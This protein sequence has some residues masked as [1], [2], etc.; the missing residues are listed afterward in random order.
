MTTKIK[1]GAKFTE[2]YDLD[3]HTIYKG[4]SDALQIPP[5]GHFLHDPTA[6]TTFDPL[7]VDEM[8]R[9]GKLMTTAIEVWTDPDEGILWVIDGRGR[10][11]DVREVNRRRLAEGR[12]PVMPSVVPF[13]GSEKDAVAR[14][15]I[16]NYHRR[17]PTPSGMGLDLKILRDA[18]WSW[19]DCAAKMHV[20]TN[21]AEQW[22][23]KLIALAYCIAPV[24]E[25][26]DAGLL[27]RSVAVKFG[28]PAPDGSKKLGKEEQKS[29]LAEMLAEKSAPKP[30]PKTWT[31][32]HQQRVAHALG[33]GASEKLNAEDRQ[34]AAIVAATLKRIQGDAH[35]LSS[36]PEVEKVVNQALKDKAKAKAKPEKDAS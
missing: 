24:R 14:V 29:L 11:L 2:R 33:N 8:D 15:R 20:A 19:A 7:M 27:P 35:A 5:P 30:K 17:V 1:S 36:W 9:A 16:K 10:L 34:V 21:D 13:Y 6:R 26:I 32:K 23:R 3:S 28:G 25:A 4:D 12:E 22:G 18:G 31:P